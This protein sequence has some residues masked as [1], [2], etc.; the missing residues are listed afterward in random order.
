MKKILLAA[1]LGL[2]LQGHSALAAEDLFSTYPVTHEVSLSTGDKVAMPFQVHNADATMVLGTADITS[3][4]S[5]LR[6][7]G[8]VI[9]AE[10]SPSR[11]LV[12][13]FMINYI[14]V[15][16]AIGPYHEIF[17]SVLTNDKKKSASNPLKSYLGLFKIG[18]PELGKFLSSSPNDVGFFAL[19]L[20]VNNEVALAAG[21][22][23][24]GFNKTMADI[25]F[26]QG[27]NSK[28][29]RV[30]DKDGD[31]L[32]ASFG[33]LIPLAHLTSTQLDF[34]CTTPKS[35]TAPGQ[36]TERAVSQSK[37]STRLFG[38]SDYLVFNDGNKWGKM[39]NDMDFQPKSWQDL[40][41][42]QMVILDPK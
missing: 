37:S 24:W 39:M 33:S 9:P 13:I 14:D 12:G 28:D 25:Q 30:S 16:K 32:K 3:L 23:I 17:I 15:D 27:F 40:K 18:M 19:K 31:I 29:I 34:M 41:D 5:I 21:N 7:Q 35:A 4:R 11:G 26:Q 22:E 42:L 8:G 1:S 10:V 6:K 2:V 36:T 38:G 20:W